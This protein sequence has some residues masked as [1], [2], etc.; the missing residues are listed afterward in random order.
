MKK[1]NNILTL[2]L[3]MVLCFQSSVSNVSAEELDVEVFEVSSLNYSGT[4][5]NYDFTR[6]NTLNSLKIDYSEPEITDIKSLGIIKTS[7]EDTDSALITY[8][9]E[10]KT[11]MEISMLSVFD[12]NEHLQTQ[13]TIDIDSW[14]S[15]SI[16]SPDETIRNQYY[17]YNALKTV[18]IREIDFLE[19]IGEL[20]LSM[21]F[22]P[23]LCEIDEKVIIGT[24]ELIS[25]STSA[26]KSNE[27]INGSESIVSFELSEGY[28]VISDDHVEILGDHLGE[29]EEVL[30]EIRYGYS[31]PISTEIQ[32][33]DIEVVYGDI[34]NS[35]SIKLSPQINRI[36][37]ILSINQFYHGF[38]ENADGV[39]E[40]TSFVLSTSDYLSSLK[41]VVLKQ[42]GLKYI[43]E[44]TSIVELPVQ[45]KSTS[46]EDFINNDEYRDGTIFFEKT[47]GIDGEENNDMIIGIS[48]S[49][50]T[51]ISLIAISTIIIKRNQNL[52]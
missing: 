35:I 13:E 12:L 44:T 3:C 8:Q 19:I 1:I 2:S 39:L 43:V 6:G 18:E 15:Y 37:T 49:L 46:Y 38:T 45:L 10:V 27:I 42:V 11:E 7:G 5:G 21:N 26:I 47:L 17:E 41:G 25:P 29:I 30:P 23:L 33:D 34:A 36:D 32:N 50:Y 16:N 52:N 31:T 24:S 48:P 22:N 40:R 9:A 51:L 20:D 4:E 28:S 14:Y